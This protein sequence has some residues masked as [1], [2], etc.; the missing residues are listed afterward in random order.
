LSELFKTTVPAANPG[1]GTVYGHARPK[2]ATITGTA[3]AQR[4]A[5]D[6]NLS[7]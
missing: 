2:A 3:Q 5:E 7:P 4:K 6:T 1:R